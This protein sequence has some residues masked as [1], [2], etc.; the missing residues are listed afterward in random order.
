MYNRK[1]L[2]SFHKEAFLSFLHMHSN[3]IIHKHVHVDARMKRYAR[4]YF[5]IKIVN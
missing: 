4:T 2:K 3:Q 1:L 5:I